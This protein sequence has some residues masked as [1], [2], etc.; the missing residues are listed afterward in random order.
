MAQVTNHTTQTIM[1]LGKEPQYVIID[2]EGTEE[3]DDDIVTAW[4]STAGGDAIVSAKGVTIV[5]GDEPGDAVAVSPE[6][7]D[8]LKLRAG[9]AIKLVAKM[10][11]PD[12][13]AE[14]AALEGLKPTVD[15]AI[16]ARLREVLA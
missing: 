13:I 2:S 12:S 4:A 15:R 1:M 6:H 3:V 8:F 7:A 16:K 10:S 11:D 5:F 9:D 14:F